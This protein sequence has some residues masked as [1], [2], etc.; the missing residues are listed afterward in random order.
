MFGA[1]W[2]AVRH[3]AATEAGQTEVQTSARPAQP[4]PVAT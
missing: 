4:E 2:F 3:R 1:T